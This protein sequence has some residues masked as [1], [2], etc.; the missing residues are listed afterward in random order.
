MKTAPL[1]WTACSL[2]LAL[3]S[4][5]LRAADDFTFVDPTGP[6]VAAIVAAGEAATKQVAVKLVAELTVAIAAS[7]PVAAIE[8][9]HLKALPL[10]AE[11][12]PGLPQVVSA[13]R[14]SLKLRNPANRPDAAEAATLAHLARLVDRGEPTP[15]L[16]L[17][18]LGPA[19]APAE[20]R[21]YRPILVQPACLTCHGDPAAQP[22]ELR[23][24]LQQRYPQ[25]AA[26]GYKEG[27]WRGLISATV[28]PHPRA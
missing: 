23:T 3:G 15:P 14:T 8:V 4:S 19:T 18:R 5:P 24:A 26:T 2:V 25:D 6:E 10:T 12:L 28:A 27:D 22:A 7:G 21:V 20:W 16:V 13:K 11:K 17:Q 1:A 9:C